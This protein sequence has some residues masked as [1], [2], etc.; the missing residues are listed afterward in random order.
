MSSRSGTVR[1][2]T[3]DHHWKKLMKYSGIHYD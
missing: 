3:A 2:I 1:L